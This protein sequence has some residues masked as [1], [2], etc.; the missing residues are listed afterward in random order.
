M[1]DQV[2]DILPIRSRLRPGETE[3][4]EFVYYGHAGR[5]FRG[6]ALCEVEGGPTYELSLLGEGSTVSYQL[7]RAF[8]D[9]GKV[10]HSRREE[11]EFYLLNPSKVTFSFKINLDKVVRQGVV[12]VSPSSGKVFGGEKQKIIVR[13]TPGIPE[14]MCE[15]LLIEVA[16]F[17]PIEFPVYGEGVYVGVGVSLPRDLTK[18]V[19]PWREEKSEVPLKWSDVVGE[20]K[21]RL[22]QMDP[23]LL[24]RF[25][26]SMDMSPPSSSGTMGA[27]G[28]LSQR[29]ARSLS[30]GR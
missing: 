26:H 24:P 21:K 17:D 6:T 11:K 13:F 14:I 10:L 9:F 1:P 19:F 27:S 18:P 30:T 2:F 28:S 4:V 20:A 29:S 8:L 12:D 5:K 7:D 3:D 15:R 16:H 25:F 23:S 22:T